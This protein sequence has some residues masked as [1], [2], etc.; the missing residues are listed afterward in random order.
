M[1]AFKLNNQYK[2]TVYWTVEECKEHGLKYSQTF[3]RGFGLWKDNFDAMCLKTVLKHL[4]KKYAPKSIESISRAIASDQASFVGD[5]EN[6]SAV[7]VDNKG[8]IA[9]SEEVEYTEVVEPASEE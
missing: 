9:N 7:Y 5:I 3:K 4:L 2:K 8:D 6:P 1:A